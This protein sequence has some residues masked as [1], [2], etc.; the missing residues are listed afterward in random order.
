MTTWPPQILFGSDYPSIP[1]EYA[2]Q[3]R[4]LAWFEPTEDDLRALLHG[5]ATRLLGQRVAR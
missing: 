5:T 4:A 2:R 3:V 1:H